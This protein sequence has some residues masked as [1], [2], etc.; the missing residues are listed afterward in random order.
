M[1]EPE[2]HTGLPEFV[3]RFPDEEACAVYLEELR[4]L[5]GFTCPECGEAGEPYRFTN[6]PRVLR[7]RA[8]KRDI[9]LTAGTIMQ[10]TRQPLTT[11]FWAAYLVTSH[12]PGM[13]ALQFQR[14]LGIKYYEPAFNLLHKLRAAMVRP[15]RDR[16]GGGPEGWRV[17][18]DESYVGGSTRGEGSG[19]TH[20]ELV[21]V[22]IEVR[23]RT[24]PRTK[25]GD[26]RPS[27]RDL[28]AGRLRLHH[29][30]NRG[31]K[32]LEAFVQAAVEPGSLVITDGHAGYD[33]LGN[34]GYWHEAETLRRDA[35]AT[36]VWLPM[37]HIAVSNLKA[38]LLGI[39]HGV[40]AKHLQAYLNE[41]VFRFNR[42]FYPMSAFHS[43]LGIAV[44]TEG[45][46][47]DGLYQGTW[48]HP[49][50]TARGAGQ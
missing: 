17:E 28:I 49:N 46:T 13:S 19:V 36:E 7:C 25:R 41:Y 29:I 32:T 14:Q 16:I 20:K 3:A 23:E 44:Q 43:V 38:W 40:S 4:W 9:S 22:A 34:L 26:G 10:D 45:P 8:C 12:T 21:A 50:P 1:L 47:Y 35:D 24:K 31:R 18:V 48:R 27:R 42:R 6:R 30:P 2:R 5:E 33:G 15:Q 11:W 39:H 37:C